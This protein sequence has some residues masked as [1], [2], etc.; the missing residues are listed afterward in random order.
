[1]PGKKKGNYW[2]PEIEALVEHVDQIF[3]TKL[4]SW[5]FQNGWVPEVEIEFCCKEVQSI[6]RSKLP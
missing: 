5:I 2:V 4:I 6:G 3:V 1:M